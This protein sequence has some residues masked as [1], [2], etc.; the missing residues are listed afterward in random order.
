VCFGTRGVLWRKSH[1]VEIVQDAGSL[2]NT[3]GKEN[4]SLGG[5]KGYIYVSS[6]YFP[7]QLVRYDNFDSHPAFCWLMNTHR[8]SLLFAHP[9]G[10]SWMRS[11]KTSFSTRGEA[12][13]RCQA[14]LLH[15]TRLL[16]LRSCASRS[17]LSS[18]QVVPTVQPSNTATNMP[19][20]GKST[21]NWCHRIENRSLFALWCV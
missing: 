12:S 10:T 17:K 15:N 4:G 11:L 16:L 6:C 13:L 9:P 20:G 1:D 2:F 3:G 19:S 5:K 18:S 21:C 14:L 7:V 8:P